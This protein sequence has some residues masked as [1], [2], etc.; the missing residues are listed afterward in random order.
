MESF[1]LYT[2]RHT[3]LIISQATLSCIIHIIKN[4]IILHRNYLETN[5]EVENFQNE[6]LDKVALKIVESCKERNGKKINWKDFQSCYSTINETFEQY[7][8]NY[9]SPYDPLVT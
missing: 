1:I 6:L 8:L 2:L 4:M 9:F 7:N 5:E 3:N